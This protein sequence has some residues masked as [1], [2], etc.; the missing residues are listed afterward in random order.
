MDGNRV[1]QDLNPFQQSRDL[2]VTSR[3]LAH[4]LGTT[5]CA[6]FPA[7]PLEQMH[8]AS[9]A[10]PPKTFPLLKEPQNVVHYCQE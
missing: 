8:N 2:H 4:F 1:N 3:R 6:D 5:P 7:A 10:T 9:V